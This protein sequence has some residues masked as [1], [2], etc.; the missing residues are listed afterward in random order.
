MATTTVPQPTQA[1][2]DVWQ[3]MLSILLSVGTEG[4]QAPIGIAQNGPGSDILAIEWATR[5]QML[6]WLP[7]FGIDPGH[8]SSVIPSGRWRGWLV[9]L[10]SCER[11]DALLAEL[12]AIPVT[13]VEVT[14]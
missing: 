2:P 13:V 5:D 14:R 1:P 4:R 3:S 8:T 10:S 11:A 12:A 9:Q 6:A 7:W